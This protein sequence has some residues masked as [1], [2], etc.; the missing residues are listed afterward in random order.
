[1]VEYL[2]DVFSQETKNAP[3]ALLPPYYRARLK[4]LPRDDDKGRKRLVA[5]LIAGM[6]ESQTLAVY[7]R[8]TGMV[9]GSAL[10][11]ILL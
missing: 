3:S 2:F 4:D 11:K 5:D 8:L 7:Q 9:A 6:T 10:D 1:M